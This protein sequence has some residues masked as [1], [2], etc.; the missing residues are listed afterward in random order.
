MTWQ[1]MQEVAMHRASLMLASSF[2]CCLQVLLFYLDL[3]VLSFRRQLLALSALLLAP[4]AFCPSPS[5]AEWVLLTQ[6]SF[7]AVH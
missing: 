3:A 6:C 5:G 2:S 7:V 4:R 1:W